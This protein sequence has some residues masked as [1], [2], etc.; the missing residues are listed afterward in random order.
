MI[1]LSTHQ[2]PLHT[3]YHAVVDAT[4]GNTTLDPV[5]ATLLDTNIVATG[6]VYE[7]PGVRGRTVKLNV[8][9]DRGRLEDI[10]RMAVNTP[11]A[12]MTGGLTLT[13]SLVIPSSQQDV[14]DKLEL[15]GRFKIEADAA[16]FRR[17]ISDF[18]GQFRLGKARLSMPTLTFNVPGAVVSM[19]GAYTLRQET[20]AFSGDLYMDGKI[21]Q[22]M[23]GFRSLLLRM[24]DPL[25]RRDGKTVVPL[26]ISGTRNDPQ[27]GLDTRRVFR[28]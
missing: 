21:S 3:T 22:T 5:H 17:V 18:A 28:H 7:V 24:V 20:L 25:F 1:N 2:A 9:I 8:S 13:T 27:F 23:S 11:T 12:P 14:V 26:K 19:K 15:A 16:E 4:N 6:G 10:M